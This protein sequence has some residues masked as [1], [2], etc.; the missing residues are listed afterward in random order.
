MELV[1]QAGGLAPG[2]GGVA[3]ALVDAAVQTVE[4]A[5]DR[6]PVAVVAPIVIAIAMT[7]AAG[8]GIDAIVNLSGGGDRDGSRSQG[9]DG[10]EKL[11]HHRT[12]P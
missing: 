10:D 2:Q 4:T 5:L 9:E 1:A 3:D 7:M 11:L 12:S 6:H 8:P